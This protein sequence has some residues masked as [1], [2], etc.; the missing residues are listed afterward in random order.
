MSRER[1]GP[2]ERGKKTKRERE[3]ERSMREIE[4]GGV[5]EAPSCLQW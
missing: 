3:R 5:K 1:K 4:R 2:S